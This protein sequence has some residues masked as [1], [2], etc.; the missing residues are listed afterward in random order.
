[1][2]R[3]H[4]WAKRQTTA[5]GIGWTALS[6]GFATCQDPAALQRDLRPA[7]TRDHPGLLRAVD[8]RLA[9]AVDRTR[10]CRGLL[11][12]AVDAPDRGLPDHGLRRTTAGQGVLRSAGRR[13]PGRGPTRQR[14]A[15]L[16]RAQAVSYTHLRAHET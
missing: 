12:G 5:A 7:R 10:P 8:G 6:N 1:M 2:S 9:V 16:H 3:A 13:Q 15:D 14:R 11:V 4:E